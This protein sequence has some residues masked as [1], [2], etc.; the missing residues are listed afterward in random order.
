MQS[1]NGIPNEDTKR[2]LPHSASHPDQYSA[3]VP[4]GGLLQLERVGM[5]VCFLHLKNT[6]TFVLL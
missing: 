4:A 2:S 3:G 1:F 5:K 6:S